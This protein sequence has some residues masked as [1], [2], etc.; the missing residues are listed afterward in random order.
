MVCPLF[1]DELDGWMDIKE[2]RRSLH[3]DR[4]NCLPNMLSNDQQRPFYS[5]R[6]YNI[7]GVCVSTYGLEIIN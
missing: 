7:M 1:G 6:R 5:N 2:E 3:V 4:E